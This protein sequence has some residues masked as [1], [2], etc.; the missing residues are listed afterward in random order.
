MFSLCWELWFTG[1][2][3]MSACLDNMCY[4]EALHP[5]SAEKT[6]WLPDTSCGSSTSIVRGVLG[7]GSC[8]GKPWEF[9]LP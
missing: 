7:A 2:R 4:L 1:R 5:I 8:P 6:Y 3:Q 9:I